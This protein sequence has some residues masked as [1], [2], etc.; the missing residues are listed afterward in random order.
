MEEDRKELVSE[1]V[2]QSC[3]ESLKYVMRRPAG[4][5]IHDDPQL[6]ITVGADWRTPLA[7]EPYRATADGFL[8]NGHYAISFDIP[9][10]GERIEPYGEGI[11]GFCNA[12]RS[13]EDPFERFVRDA[14]AVIDDCIRSGFATPGKIAV[15]GASRGAYLAFRLLIA[16][17]RVT[18]AAGFAPVTDWRYLSEFGAI[19]DSDEVDAL[20]L[21][22]YVENLAGKPLFIAIGNRDIRV[23]TLSCCKLYTELTERNLACGHP[24]SLVEFFC[25]DDPGHTMGDRWYEKGTRFLL[26]L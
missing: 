10:H 25:T 9:C 15:C 6:L 22:R 21:H 23:S 20:K 13:G 16:D 2:I 8:A 24:E 5:R 17:S 11:G 18:R 12:L 4:H 1:H 26:N 7:T 19:K 3:G 14:R